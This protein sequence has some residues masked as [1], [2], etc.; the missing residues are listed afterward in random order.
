[1]SEDNDD[2]DAEGFPLRPK[3]VSGAMETSPEKSCEVYMDLKRR[4]LDLETRKLDFEIR[5]QEDRHMSMD[6]SKMHAIQLKW[7]HMRAN[8][9]AEKRKVS[10]MSTGDI[11]DENLE[12]EGCNDV[13]QEEDMHS[14]KKKAK[15]M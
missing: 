14:R 12:D 6:I 7:W 11:N 3:S 10:D 9:I 2:E 4:K 15:M 5:A 8:E 1:D 13:E